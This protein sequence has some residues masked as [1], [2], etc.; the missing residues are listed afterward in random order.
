MLA[1]VTPPGLSEMS[2][3]LHNRKAVSVLHKSLHPPPT[4][5]PAPQGG[6]VRLWGLVPATAGARDDWP[7][8]A[9]VTV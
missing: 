6:I 7:M 8:E 4:P 5:S 2:L 3:L 1:E 9:G